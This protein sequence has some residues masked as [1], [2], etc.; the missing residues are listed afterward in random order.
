MYYYKMDNLNFVKLKASVTY[1]LYKVST[2]YQTLLD[3]FLCLQTASLVHSNFRP[4]G[5]NN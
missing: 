5:N 2:L 1:P 3:Y 4:I